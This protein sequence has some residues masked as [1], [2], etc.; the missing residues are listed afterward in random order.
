MVEQH[1]TER[2]RALD[3]ELTRRGAEALVGLV[4]VSV[5][6]REESLELRR[7]RARSRGERIAGA[8]SCT[9]AIR[10]WTVVSSSSASAARP[11]S[12]VASR[13]SSLA[14]SLP[15]VAIG[16]AASSASRCLPATLRAIARATA[17]P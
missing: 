16:S 5:A 3:G 2:E 8:S 13:R 6:R 9:D 17:G 7:A 11:A 10:R 15:A 12:P 14:S 1:L 4:E